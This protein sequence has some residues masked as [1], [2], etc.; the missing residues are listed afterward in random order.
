MTPKQAWRFDIRQG[1]L[2]NGSTVG[3]LGVARR[4]GGRS[5]QLTRRRSRARGTLAAASVALVLLLAAPT[6]A[7]AD[8]DDLPL[9]PDAAP[10]ITSPDTGNFLG[11]AGT[12]VTGTKAAG[13][14]VQILAGSSR[15]NVCTVES[16]DTEFSC[17]VSRLPSG[18]S[19]TLSAVQLGEGGPN[20]ESVPVVI[21]VLAEPTIAGSTLQLTSGLIQGGG[22]PNA[23]ITLS[24]GGGSSWSFPAGPD[25]TWAYVLPRSIG[26]GV[27]TLT[28]TQATSFSHGRQSNPAPA[29][30]ILLDIDAPAVPRLTSPAPGSTV[31]TSGVVF[32]GTGEDRA[33]VEVFAVTASGSD[34]ALCSAVV[35][36]GSWTC[37]GGAV[38]PGTARV[39]AFQKDAAGNVGGGS[40]PLEL[41]IVAPP[42]ASPSPSPSPEN[43]EEPDPAP[44]VPAIPP[45]TPSP[46]PSGSG[47]TTTPEAH[48]WVNA[49][50]FTS[51]V[52][53]ALGAVDLSWLRALLLAAVAIL[54][55]LVPARMLATTVGA[56]RAGHRPPSLTGRNRVPTH[57]DPDPLISTPGAVL[58][59]GGVVVA[60]SGIVLFANPVHGQPEYLRVFLASVIAITLLNVASTHLPKLL[61]PRWAGSAARIALSPRFLIAVAAVALFSRLLDLQ[62]ALLFG[63]VFTVSAV[64][65]LRAARGALALIRIGVVFTFGLVAWLASTV[66][67][68]PSG[69]ADILIT[70]VANIAATA[71]IGSAAILLVPLGRLDG[72]ALLIWS[73][74][75][76]FAS[77][78]VVLTVLF[79]LLAPV[80]DVWQ[81]SGGILI[82]LFA[83]LV[84]GAIGISVWL[85]RRLIQPDL[86]SE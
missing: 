46:T 68:A 80:V 50:P 20:L 64:T 23:T 85:W 37:T 52:P 35:S 13:A 12:V 4:D 79:A 81:N 3:I 49:T 17:E 24:A 44:V 33:T 28:A 74:P 66:L 34:V 8:P 84:F 32:A 7:H 45:T 38:P 36:R 25:G 53:S 18:P 73:R 70:E 61:A 40:A 15:T 5:A 19:I 43:S 41:R 2:V 75:A 57:D 26:S 39:T 62:P 63:V 71:G 83:L 22:Y 48:G 86:T 76:W 21:D 9:A 51:G 30:R 58:T 1:R 6:A 31:R 11:S 10:T 77:A 47:P 14:E 54:L 60:A 69:F 67:G 27:H 65:G 16:D 29:R 42:T 55:L 78:V 56:R 59:A 82:G 72:R